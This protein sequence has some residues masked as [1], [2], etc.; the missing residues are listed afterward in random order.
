MTSLIRYGCISDPTD[1]SRRHRTFV[2]CRVEDWTSLTNTYAREPDM[3]LTLADFPVTPEVAAAAEEWV[4]EQPSK[5]FV[6]LGGVE[7]GQWAYWNLA[8]IPRPPV[9]AAV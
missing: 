8:G 6:F 2:A 5:G 3:E 7:N 1:D 4:G 9:P